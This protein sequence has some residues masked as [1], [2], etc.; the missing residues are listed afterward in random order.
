MQKQ[1]ARS[2]E[3]FINKDF[4]LRSAVARELYHQSAEGRP[5]IDYHCHLSPRMI[6]E[7]HK[8][9]DITEI[10]LGADHYKWRAMRGNGVPEEYIT[11]NRSSWGKF[12]KGA[13][14]VP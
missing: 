9:A 3:P 13:E 2:M 14:T 1:T 12:E 11:G 7:N 4:L 6:A 8:F 10:W 5:I